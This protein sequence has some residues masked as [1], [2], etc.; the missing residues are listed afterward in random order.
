MLLAI[1]LIFGLK[2]RWRSW[3]LKEALHILGEFVPTSKLQVAHRLGPFRMRTHRLPQT[4]DN[5]HISC[6]IPTEQ[7]VTK[8]G[9]QD[10]FLM[11]VTGVCA[12]WFTFPFELIQ[13]YLPF[14]ECR[15][16]NGE[17]R[18]ATSVRVIS[19]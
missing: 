7:F 9:C 14:G 3:K 17:W 8:L 19:W 16:F 10:E 5:I 6:P 11:R 4:V 12:V 15:P 18:A 2:Y 13:W 1:F